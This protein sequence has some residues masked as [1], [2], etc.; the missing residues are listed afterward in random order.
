LFRSINK[1]NAERISSLVWLFS[2]AVYA[3]VAIY[4]LSSNFTI[5]QYRQAQ[6]AITAFYLPQTGFSLDYL[7]PIMGHPWKVPL[8][9]PFFQWAAAI[10]QKITGSD[11]VVCGKLINIF[12]HI[13]TNFLILQLFKNRQLPVTIAY[14]G[15]IFYNL[16]PFYLV[17]DS[18]FLIDTFSLTLA[19]ATAWLASLYL[20]PQSKLIWLLLF[21]IAAVCTGV[22]KSTTFIGVL[23]P[24]LAVMLLQELLKNGGIKN[25]FPLSASTKKIAATGL[26]FLIAFAVMYT[27]VIFSDEVKATNPLSAEWTSANTKTWSFG[28]IE[29]RLSFANW[30]QYM[31]Y[32]MLMHPLIYITLALLLGLFLFVSSKKQRKLLL[33]FMFLFFAPLLIFFNLFFIHT[34]YSVANMLFFYLI[35]ATLIVALLQN[36]KV[37]VKYTGYVLCSLVLLFGVYRSY[38]FRNQITKQAVEPGVYGQL[39]KIPL[40]AGTNDVIVTVQNSRDPFI[41]Y[42]FKCRGINLNKQE[43]KLYGANGKLQQL[44]G[45]LRVKMICIVE[46]QPLDVLPVAYSG[47]LQG[48]IRHLSLSHQPEANTFYNFFWQQ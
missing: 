35:L 36:D 27:W 13:I 42:Y 10:L 9:I 28:T 32:S 21:L 15:L 24:V 41:Q 39:N 12:C 46:E 48:D 20:K 45:G 3:F 8:E 26:C 4:F 31:T 5:H 14:T 38:A 1:L 25:L 30:K 6:T 37:A 40:K 16:F 47:I 19:F 22:S 44:T 34:Y 43:Y 33:C 2:L 11:L 29:Q 23:A 17:F 18:V 7:T